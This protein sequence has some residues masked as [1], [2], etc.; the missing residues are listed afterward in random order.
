MAIA[1]QKLL[2]NAEDFDCPICFTSIDKGEGVMLRE[3]LHTCC[4][5]VAK[6]KFLFCILCIYMR[7]TSPSFLF[8]I[9][10]YFEPTFCKR[11]A[12]VC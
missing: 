2:P 7:V 1:Q 8:G 5:Y 4:K 10:I 12:L 9:Y 6:Y 3:C 11:N